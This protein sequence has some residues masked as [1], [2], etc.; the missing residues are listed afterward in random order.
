MARDKG[1]GQLG[2][3][4]GP[5]I[6]YERNG[7]QCIRSMPAQVHNPR[8]PAQQYNRKKMTAISKLAS[9]LKPWITVTMNHPDYST[10]R[11]AFIAL[12][13]KHAF[14][15]VNGE[16]VLMPQKLIVTAG[17]LKDKEEYTVS[18][19]ESNMLEFQWKKDQMLSGS[20]SVH[21]LI[22]TQALSWW[23]YTLHAGTE[24]AGMATV[25]LPEEA[26]ESELIYWVVEHR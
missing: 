7:K 18:K 23:A 22:C 19:N 5:V 11:G 12:N 25:Q 3:K 20:G 16:P 21:V 24:E 4:I 14:E 6:V 8:T 13:M 10:P 2:G 9:V 15:E 17:G 1:N 26:T